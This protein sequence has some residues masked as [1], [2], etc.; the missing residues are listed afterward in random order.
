MADYEPIDLSP[1]CN[2]GVEALAS[3]VDPPVGPQSF[4]GLPFLIG[5]SGAQASGGRC[6]IVVGG[7]KRPVT[8][9]I[10]RRARQVIF[11]HRLLESELPSGAIPGQVVAEY[12]FH[13]QG[14]RPVAVP[15]RE[16]FEVSALF[17]FGWTPFRALTDQ[18]FLP[19]PRYQGPW[20]QAGRRQT[21][22][23]QARPPRTTSGPGRTPTQ[24]PR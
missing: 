12:V 8:V 14:R 17:G 9:P 22:V 7:N 15:V 10:G 6:F 20:E 2:A 18:K 11:A 13:L 1:W 3:E 4:H 21:E 5:P 23:G 16:R 19:L 24:R